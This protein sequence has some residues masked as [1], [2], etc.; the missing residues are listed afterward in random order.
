MANEIPLDILV[1]LDKSINDIQKFREKTE[2]SLKSIQKSAEAISFV[3]VGRAAISAGQKI[4]AALE[5]VI[6]ASLESE[7]AIKQLEASLRVTGS[8][9]QEN[10][11]RFTAL[12]SEIET[13][14]G[15]SDEAVL[16]QIAYV[17]ALGATNN[18]TEKIIRTATELSAAL[19]GDLASRTQELANTFSGVIP[20]ALGKAIPELLKLSQAQLQSGAAVDIIAHKYN[21]FAKELSGSSSVQVELLAQRFGNLKEAIGDNITQSSLFKNSLQFLNDSLLKLTEGAKNI[22]L[23]STVQEVV[24]LLANASAIVYKTNSYA[25]DAVKSFFGWKKPL[26]ESEETLYNHGKILKDTAGT[27]AKV[28][29]ETEKGG[30]GTNAIKT[31]I[32]EMASKAKALHE[33]LK[34][35]GLSPKEAL[36]RERNERFKIIDDAVSHGII[37]EKAAVIE[38]LK[39]EKDFREKSLQLRV[40]ETKDFL[41]LNLFDEKGKIQLPDSSIQGVALGVGVASQAAKGVE[42][43]RGILKTGATVGGTALFGPEAGQVIGQITEL[44]SQSPEQLKASLESFF[45][46]IPVLIENIIENIPLIMQTFAEQTPIIIDKIIS[47]LPRILQAQIENVPKLFAAMAAEAPKIAISL[48]NKMPEVAVEFAVNLIKSIPSIVK[49]FVNQIKGQL[50]GLLGSSEGGGNGL[51]GGAKAFLT[52]GLSKVFKFADG[53]IVPSGFPNDSAPAL[54]TSG[55]IVLNKDGVDNMIS[56]F[57][58]LANRRPTESNGSQNISI[59]L[60]VGEKQLADVLLQLNR[61][62]FRTV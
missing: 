5:D 59:N 30:L 24:P 49:E 55:E 1:R 48:A 57:N 34:D 33:Q 44:L 25:L 16:G 27:V 11:A 32:D 42:G 45:Q 15:I 29:A 7:K 18:Q 39:I 58:S 2:S 54:L 12:A 37:S 50:G 53:G 62:G 35:V 41:A 23:K 28:T 3:E 51:I 10:V 13:L 6:K 22:S 36:V 38:R 40:K 20:K 47:D 46:A 17:K 26:K 52:G 8:A 60:Q 21:G 14:T 61:N 31:N 4:V 19:G 43:A 9:T 56:A